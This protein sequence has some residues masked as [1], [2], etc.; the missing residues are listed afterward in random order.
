MPSSGPRKRRSHEHASGTARSGLSVPQRI[1]TSPGSRHAHDAGTV[2]PDE[3]DAL[4]PRNVRMSGTHI[5]A[6]LDH[7]VV[8][9]EPQLD[10]CSAQARRSRSGRQPGHAGARPRRGCSDRRGPGPPEYAGDRLVRLARGRHVSQP[11]RRGEEGDSSTAERSRRARQPRT[12]IGQCVNPPPSSRR[13][14]RTAVSTRPFTRFR[15]RGSGR[16]RPCTGWTFSR[17]RRSAGR[18]SCWPSSRADGSAPRSCSSRSPRSIARCC[19]S[20]KS[21]TA[22]GRE[23]PAFTVAWNALV[24]VPLLIPSFLYEGV[25]TDH[26]RQSCYG[27]EADPEYVPFGRRSPL[28]ILGAVAGVVARAGRAGRSIRDSGAALLGDTRAPP[29]GGGTLLGAGHQSSLRAARA[30]RA[31]RPRA[32]SRRLPGVLD[33]GGPVVERTAADGGVVVLGHRERR[34]VGRQRRAHAGRAPLRPGLGRAVDDRAAARFVH[35]CRRRTVWRRDSPT[36]AAHWSRRS[37]CAITRCTTG[38]PRSR[39]TTSDA[40]TGCSCPRCDP[41]PRTTP[42]SSVA[43]CRRYAISCAGLARARVRDAWFSSG[44]PDATER[45]RTS[46]PLRIGICAPYDLGRDGGVNSHIRAQ[47]RALRAL[48]H[49]VCVFGA[50]SAPLADGERALS[51]C[52]SLVVGGTETGIGLDPR[53]WWRVADAVADRAV[54]RPPPARA[55]DAAR[56]VV[57]AAAVHGAG[58][59]HV[60]HAS[61]AGTSMVWPVPLAARAADAANP[62]P[63]GRLGR[64]PTHRRQRL[65]RRLR[66][67]AERDRRGSVPSPDPA[68][69]RACRRICVSCC[70]WADSNRGRASIA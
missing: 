29:A 70:S 15:S 7:R 52:I 8:E 69:G 35:D 56:A 25:H 14:G 58:G 41:T 10:G 32:G 38:F 19:S 46:R 20:T 63:P 31:R 3:V 44:R 18:R 12:L 24:G 66:D 50:S 43:S 61:R 34:R 68:A 42:R 55:A 28:L 54:R 64:R 51:G 37:A 60:P 27:T 48:G 33:V 53:S 17:R 4:K 62:H 9:V 26:H 47:A 13:P 36:P 6:R 39:T 16:F 67:R 65:S 40:R 11:V 23:L 49:D 2:A 21:R 59:R 1:E 5:A 45:R 30:H 57:R 22:P